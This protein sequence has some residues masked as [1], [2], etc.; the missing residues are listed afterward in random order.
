MEKKAESDL[1]TM[2]HGSLMPDEWP[3]K[4]TV[5]LGQNGVTV[6]ADP[7]GGIYQISSK[8]RSHKYA[9]MIAAPWPQFDQKDRQ[10]PT[11]VREYRK[12]MERRLQSKQPGLGLRLDVAKGHTVIKHVNDSLGSQVQIGYDTRGQKLL[13]QTV[14]KVQEDGTILQAIQ[15]T[16]NDQHPRNVS[17]TLD[18]SFA[19][20][21]ASYGQLTDQ[22]PVP[23][24]E[25][26]NVV[27]VWKQ[28]LVK[29]DRVS[30]WS[31]TICFDNESLGGRLS[32]KVMF[33]NVSENRFIEFDEALLPAVGTDPN[34]PSLLVESNNQQPRCQTIRLGPFQTAR[35]ACALR[36]DDILFP[37]MG[38]NWDQDGLDLKALLDPKLFAH[39]DDI[40]H[41]QYNEIQR[42]YLP[43]AKGARDS[44]ELETIESKILW[45]NV[46]Y[47]IG[48]CSTPVATSDRVCWAVIPDHI[49]LPLGWPRDNY[50]QLRLLSK[51]LTSDGFHDLFPGKASK[52]QEYSD[53]IRLITKG[54]LDWLFNTATAKIQIGNEERYFWRRSY[55]INGQPKDGSVYQLDTQLYPFLQ[56]SEYYNDLEKLNMLDEEHVA[57]V[58][59]IMKSETF[60]SVLTDILMRQD[61]ELRLFKTD[62][63]PA[64]DCTSDF[65][66]HL[67]S[68]IMVWH[69]MTKLSNLLRDTEASTWLARDLDP[70]VLERVAGQVFEGI[71]EHFVCRCHD[72]SGE[73]ML[74]YAFDPSRP[75]DHP[76]RHRRYHDGNDMPTVLAHEW[77]FLLNLP[78]PGD[79]GAVAFDPTTTAAANARPSR[80]GAWLRAVWEKTLTWAL[81]PDPRWTLATDGAARGEHAA[82]RTPGCN[83]GYAGRGTEP[84]H[85]LGSDHSAGAWVLGFYQEW[86][87][88]AAVG[89]GA[90]EA[91]AWRKIRGAMQWDGTFSEA[92]DVW[93][94]ECTSKTWFSW[95]GAMV[96]AELI[97]TVVAQTR[98]SGLLLGHIDREDDGVDCPC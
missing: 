80:D 52:A 3:K 33:Y 39:R 56:L 86:K 34:P 18:L 67:S 57:F 92:V 79:D 9:M 90:R 61:P 22:G 28:N 89:D 24:P 49:A 17:V 83:G 12:H 50:W 54:H 98:A 59:S 77:G 21:R 36:P 29:E 94:G 81:T 30:Q 91:G 35:L 7:Y 32:A 93:T 15:V 76:A 40:H 16:N 69:T 8:I 14:L 48:C 46:N 20:S 51:L 72:G 11:V 85:G 82:L 26:A 55:L 25:P 58:R 1:S 97:E 13:V 87:F 62:E 44:P 88:A 74:A 4:K 47:I 68:N 27:H 96:A 42:R 45:A 70:A 53:K 19:I 41:M 78:R 38:P 23:M 63:T 37:D 6:S 5:D 2:W 71:L 73:S 43:A 95:P 65:P 75:A 66:F 60:S 31:D 84:F 10:N 64:D